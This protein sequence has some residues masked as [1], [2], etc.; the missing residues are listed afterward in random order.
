MKKYICPVCKKV[1]YKNVY[2]KCQAV[3]CSPECAYKGRTLGITKR[4]VKK[5]YNCYR[6]P[7]R[8]CLICQ[9]EYI[10]KHK[11]QKYCSR[12][13]FEIAHKKNMLGKNNPA[14]KNGSS[15]KK[16]SFR[17]NDWETLRKEIYKRDN[18]I[19]QDCGI[20]CQSK[21]DYK[22]SDS[23][24]QC[25]HIENYK[26]GHNNKKSNLITLCLKCHLKRHN[27]N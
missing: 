13:C 21:R 11:K 18:Y 25:H 6:K 17:G 4:R 5:P 22:N 19:C 9:K 14:Y 8:I 27:K 26:K 1:F 2:K 10:Y 16:R 24:I 23:I 15:Y 7:K 20:K 12:K 3:Y